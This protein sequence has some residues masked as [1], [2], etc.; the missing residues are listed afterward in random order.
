MSS[1]NR[2]AGSGNP[3]K[4]VVRA[5][6]RRPAGPTTP[7]ARERAAA[8]RREGRTGESARTTDGSQQ[9]SQ[10]PLQQQSPFGTSGTGGIGGTAGN[11]TSGRTL[12]ILIG[13]ALLYYFVLRP[14]MQSGESGQSPE[15]VT[16]D[17]GLGLIATS[18][19]QAPVAVPTRMPAPT[20]VPGSAAAGQS[21]LVM[22]YQDA[23]D[24]VL[25][26]DIYVDLNE[27][28]RVGST[29]N[30]R[31]VAQIDRYAGGSTDDGDWTSTRR[32]YVTHDDDLTRIGSQLV[33]D[34]G[35]RNMADGN[36]LVEFAA[37][38]IETYPSDRVALIMSDHGMGWPGGW[39]DPAPATRG[40]SSTPLSSQ[41]GNQLY[42]NQ[43]DAA[44]QSIRDRT[45][46]DKLD[47]FGMDA[48]L[49]A[50]LEVFTALEPHARYAVASEETEPGLGW[51]YAGFLQSLVANPGMDGADLSRLIVDSYILDDQRIVDDEAR[52]DML[53]QGSPMSGLFG[54]TVPTSDQLAT[55]MGRDVTLSAI[56][57]SAVPALVDSVNG[58]VGALQ[59]VDQRPVAQAR[60]YAQSFTNI[61][62]S[63]VP[64]SYI[65]L[66]HWSELLKENNVGT[67]ADQ[68]VDRV[69]AALQAA[70]IAEKHGPG[71]PGASGVAIYFPNSQLYRAPVAGPPSYNV[72]AQRFAEA[73]LWDDYLAYHYT[74]RTFDASAREPVA[75]SASATVTAPGKGEFTLSPVQIS[76]SV[77]APGRPIVLRTDITARNLGQVLIFTGYVDAASRSL[78]VMDMDYL[79]SSDVREV[80]GVYYPVWPDG[81]FTLE[82]EWEPL[83]FTISDGTDSVVALLT[84]Q[85]FGAASEDAVYTVDGT[86][87]FQ[88]GETRLARLYFRDG[89]LRQVF[90][91]TGNSTAGAP[92]EITPESGDRFTVFERWLDLDDQGRVVQQATENGGTLTFRDQMFTWAMLDAPAGSYVVG[93][94]AQDLDGNQQQAYAQVTV[95]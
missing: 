28:E 78:N 72:I 76:A 14:M 81:E 88:S 19:P 6:R 62:G 67:A 64:A 8:P 95:Q 37:W 82:F 38:A 16:P 36:T 34:L 2:P 44:L 58:L 9:Q 93:F 56:D 23:D 69:L 46:I 3:D 65:D 59:E 83:T 40:D 80:N 25:E 86:Y 71:K 60:S 57:L 51:A 26:K 61:F 31:I 11:P 94:I 27:A 90:G 74:G 87:T 21:W 70:V 63:Q 32:Y 45:G 84:P 7:G 77:A 68:Q 24:K 48:C 66:G 39:S 10:Q 17:T 1:A 35:E 41:L 43:L 12:V 54:F 73:S 75:P 4:K 85:S 53:R 50:Q 52:A 42:L 5:Q 29:D 18:V 49:M 91:F 92:S 13:L 22:L 15:A 33:E 30:V 20:A 89:M 47:L 79:E 55:Q